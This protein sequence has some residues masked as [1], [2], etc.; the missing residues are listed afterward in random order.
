MKRYFA[1]LFF[2][3]LF[4]NACKKH[5]TKSG[6]DLVG[7]K[8]FQFEKYTVQNLKTYSVATDSVL[9]G[10]GYLPLGVYEHPAYGLTNADALLQFGSSQAFDSDHFKNAD[11]ILFAEIRIPFFS[12]P[13]PDHSTDSNPVYLIDSVFGS[14]PISLKAYENTYFIFPYDPN[15]G[16]Q[17]PN[18]RP[19]YSNF[20]YDAYKGD[21]LYDNPTFTPD[22]GYIIDTLPVNGINLENLAD[23]KDLNFNNDTLPP[24]LVIPIDTGFVRHKFFDHAGE[25]ILTDPN[26]FKEYF[27]GIYLDA[28]N[29]S[30]SGLMMLLGGP[31]ELVLAYRYHFINDNDTPD[32]DSDDYTDY[33]YEKIVLIAQRTINNYQ[34]HFYPQ[35]ENKLRNP[36]VSTGED[37]IYVKGEAGATAIVEIFS[38]QELYELRNNDWFINQ[39]NLRLYVD[40]TDMSSLSPREQPVQL[41]LYKYDSKQKI[42]DLIPVLDNGQTVEAS[43]LISFYNGRYALD[44]VRNMHYYEFNITRHI[45]DVL[46]KDS[47]NVRLGIRVV[48]N[49][50]GFL[51]G[52]NLSQDPDAAIPFGTVLQGNLSADLPAELTIYYTEPE[53][54]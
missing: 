26:L 53:E 44:S 50:A 18:V 46:R 52:Q 21:L 31:V 24:H 54:E 11:S 49:L 10:G 19:Y 33:G 34:N 9:S 27:R 8:K 36:S 14:A 1:G 20:D 28:E 5:F 16:F 39:A 29:I 13:D 41:Y 37:K 17:S 7:D 23:N 43:N 15:S 12:K 38:A 42:T 48:N 4:L 22:F 3:I 25:N 47:A 2:F 6:F 30:S 45:K 32:D 40:E 35:V 51:S